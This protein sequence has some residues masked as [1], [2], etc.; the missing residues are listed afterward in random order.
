MKTS[1]YRIS[2]KQ[3][4]LAA[5]FIMTAFILLA[6]ALLEPKQTASGEW[7]PL[8]EAVE[9]AVASFAK[10]NDA[11]GDAELSSEKTA[12]KTHTT[13]NTGKLASSTPE[14]ETNTETEKSAFAASK[15][16]LDV[17]TE[18]EADG[19]AHI[20]TNG[21]ASAEAEAAIEEG[22]LDINRA[23]AAELD[24]LK[25]IGPAKAQAIIRDRDENG[26]YGSVDDLLRVKGI[27]EKLLS[28]IRGS[29]VARP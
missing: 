17:E 4:L 15:V 24:A 6:A 13:S 12:A 2:N 5:I 11:V 19:E 25:G 3:L 22:K 29:I 23:T 1:S 10:P 27:G 8:N 14:A 20:E 21:E 7:V 26:K 16:G 9:T 18:V 28:G